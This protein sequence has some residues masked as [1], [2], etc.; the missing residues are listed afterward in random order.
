LI[1]TEPSDRDLDVLIVGAGLSGIGIGRQLRE[2]LPTKSF[3]ILESR[4]ASGGTWDLFRFPGI[5]SDSDMYT[6]GYEFEPWVGEES[7]A[8]GDQILGYL[9][10]TASRHG[11]DDHIR[12]RKRV[13]SAAWSS[14]DARWTVEVQDTGT[15]ERMTFTAH[16]LFCATGYFRYD[17]GHTPPFEG[18][19]RF[20]GRIIHPQHWPEDLDHR[21]QQ[22]VVIGSGS[23][24]VTLVP[25]L[26]E[27]A[28]HVTMVQRTPSYVLPVP[29]RDRT[30][31][32]LRRWFG[33]RR[34]SSLTRRLNI[35]RQRATWLLSR[36]FPATTRRLIRRISTDQLPRGFAVDEHFNPPYDPWDQRLCLAPDADLFRTIGRGDVSVVTD[37]VERFTEA[38]VQLLSGRELP[39]DIVVTATGL[40]LQLLGGIRIHVDGRLV[41][42]AGTV[43]YRG[44]MLG[45]VPNLA[46]ALGYANASWT[47]KIG[48]VGEYFSRLL[49]L[50]EEK[51]YDTA[52]AVPDP[53]MA[54]RP[55]ID[56]DSGYVRRSAAELP[57]QGDVGPWR[58]ST[59]YREDVRLLRRG[60]VVDRYLHLSGHQHRPETDY[61]PDRDG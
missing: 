61:A 9:R 35:V 8:S 11:L 54:T 47:L 25:A 31:R 59:G 60:P 18:Q 43:V 45:G 15:G 21:G 19:D 50:M 52:C 49:A 13:I 7:I 17:E 56:L 48:L 30:A 36:R 39:A 51:S 42:P 37:A 10:Q 6:L 22:I 55:L 41:S 27:E 32:R 16:W 40:N 20:R 38:G 2:D 26:A 24:A 33:E 53:T 23:T 34:G 4:H 29:L 3:L 14:P 58:A 46:F 57:K 1:T 44:L 28:G 12:Y 5:R